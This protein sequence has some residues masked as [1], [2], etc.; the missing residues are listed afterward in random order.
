MPVYPP[1]A[2]TITGENI[3][4]STFLDNPAR[5]TRVVA[6]LV[7][8]RFIADLIFSA[9]PLATGGAV[10]Y[11][12]VTGG[13]VF[14]DRDVEAIQPGAEFPLL[15]GADLLAKV[16]S[17]E[18]YGGAVEFTKEAIQ[19]NRIDLLNNRLTQL[20]NTI[21]RKADSVAIGVLDAAP[22]NNAVGTDWTAATGEQVIANMITAIG[23]INN[24]DNGYVA[25]DGFLNPTQA[26][27]IMA[28]KDVRDAMQAPG[29]PGRVLR[30]GTLGD[31]LNV[32]WHK[33]NRIPAGEL[34]VVASGSVG[35]ISDE[36][37]VGTQVFP[38]QTD[39]T[40]RQVS[41]LMGWRSFAPFV[42]DPLAVT[43][44]TGI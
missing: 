30:T 27:E 3:T 10:V 34:R 25:S 42:T 35:G 32:T 29:D 39:Q 18:K 17:V 6:D 12:Q 24:P 11:D 40:R 33:S 4:V 8:Q 21:V 1:L 37:A 38:W 19:R 20:R 26:D 7:A 36:D 15:T 5:V 9:G 14:L 2:P 22:I 31:I 28:K 23:L 43:R 13:Y 16:A 44:M 41:T